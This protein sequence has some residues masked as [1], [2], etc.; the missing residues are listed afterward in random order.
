MDENK[1]YWIF[2][3]FFY[4]NPELYMCI[5]VDGMNQNTT[6]ILK[7]RQT[8]KNIEHQFVKTYLY[9]AL[10]HEVGL[11]CDVWFGAQYKHNSNQVVSTLLFVIGGVLRR[12]GFLPPTSCIQ[13]DNCTR[14]NKNI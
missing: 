11:Y 5:I 6:M 9:G 13:A 4:I 2:K 8:V 12:K 1:H 14:E 3:R 7:I 10:V